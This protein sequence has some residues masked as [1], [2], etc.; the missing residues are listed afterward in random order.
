V[1]SASRFAP[2]RLGEV[3]M[4][5]RKILPGEPV[6]MVG[7]KRFVM[8]PGEE[9]IGQWGKWIVVN[10]P[11]W[12]RDGWDSLKIFRDVKGPK[13]LWQIGFKNGRPARNGAKRLLEEYYPEALPAITEIVVKWQKGKTIP[14]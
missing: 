10:V 2:E 13:N 3:I 7:G 8:Q 6:R 9:V 4:A 5:R 14:E 12:G 11:E 1:R